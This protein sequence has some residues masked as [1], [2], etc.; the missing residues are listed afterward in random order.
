MRAG[1]TRRNGREPQRKCEARESNEEV[2][3]ANDQEG[4]QETLAGRTAR[5]SSHAP[6]PC[7]RPHHRSGLSAI[8]SHPVAWLSASCL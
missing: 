6:A 8:R 2:E 3:G 1:E 7:A 4:G 5:G